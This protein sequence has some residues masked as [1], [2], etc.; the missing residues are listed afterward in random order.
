MMKRFSFVKLT[1]F[2]FFTHG[3]LAV[4]ITQKVESYS[5]GFGATRVIYTPSSKG[6]D[7]P[8]WNPNDYPML[9]QTVVLNED[10]K[11]KAPYIATPPLFRLE[12]HQ[13]SRIRVVRLGNVIDSDRE[14]L[15]WLCLTGIPPESGD[16]WAMAGNNVEKQKAVTLDVKVKMTR[17]IKLF[18]R[19]DS[20]KGN[21]LDRGGELV[22]RVQGERLRVDNPTPFNMS[23]AS[24]HVGGREIIVSDYIPPFSSREFRYQKGGGNTVRWTLISDLGGKSKVYS[25]SLK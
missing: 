17:C 22:W 7:L 1:V 10:K 9:V 8:V 14:S 15:R 20:L 19:P 3:A 24:L 4:E 13:Q 5:I 25:T 23:F 21:S 16:A 18:E 2:L 11:G 6:A 12:G